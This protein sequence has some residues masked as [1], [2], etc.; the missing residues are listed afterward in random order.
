MRKIFVASGLAVICVAIFTN[1]SIGL[2]K[3]STEQN[4]NPHQQESHM[5][6][7]TQNPAGTIDGAVNPEQ[8]PDTTAYELFFNFFVDRDENERG[9][10]QAYCKQTS[11]VDVDLD[12][13]LAAARSYKQQVVGLDMEAEA[14]R[15]SETLSTAAPKLAALRARREEVVQKLMADLPQF[16]GPDGA[17]AIRSHINNRMKPNIKIIPGPKIPNQT[18]NGM[19][20]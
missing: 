14:V 13:L 3:T 16:V 10:L 7:A 20:H 8:I 4:A 1:V 9:K 5:R 18:S 11:L 15:T 19:V 12:G 6:S 17:A 2:N